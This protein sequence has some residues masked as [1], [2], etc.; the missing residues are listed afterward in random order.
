LEPDCREAA[1]KKK[2]SAGTKQ[3]KKSSLPAGKETAAE[4]QNGAVEITA[5][6]T[7]EDPPKWSV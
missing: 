5:E 6:T 3:S 4:A 1:I 7:A 2:K